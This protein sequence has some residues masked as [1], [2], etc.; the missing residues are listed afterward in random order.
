[1][2]NTRGSSARRRASASRTAEASE[3]LHVLANAASGIEAA[4]RERMWPSRLRSRGNEDDLLRAERR[5][6]LQQPLQTRGTV[7]EAVRLAAPV[8]VGGE[9]HLVQSCGQRYRQSCGHRIGQMV[10]VRTSQIKHFCA[11]RIGVQH[12]RTPHEVA[13]AFVSH[14]GKH[15][16][17]ACVDVVRDDDEFAEARL[18][19]IVGE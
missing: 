13:S 14:K 16:I 18:P 6:F 2:R 11:P 3:D 1:M 8:A 19:E 9:L 7:A 12:E 4:S 10:A 17:A 5:Q 15:Q